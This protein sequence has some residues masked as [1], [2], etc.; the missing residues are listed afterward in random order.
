MTQRA[1][2]C[3]RTGTTRTWQR[4]PLAEVGRPAS[5]VRLIEVP[6]SQFPTWSH[7]SVSLA[8]SFGLLPSSLGAQSARTFDSSSKIC[9]FCEV[10]LRFSISEVLKPGWATN[11]RMT[12][13]RSNSRA[14]D[15]LKPQRCRDFRELANNSKSVGC[16]GRYASG[17]PACPTSSREKVI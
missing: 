14:Q 16:H 17:T 5:S 6:V 10:A 4:A 11:C 12:N 2:A 8:A 13:S 9:A 1:R 3:H 15:P 7:D